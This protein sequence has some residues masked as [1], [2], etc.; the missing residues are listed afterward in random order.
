MPV[1]LWNPISI[2]LLSQL[3][4]ASVITSYFA[5][6]AVRNR[7]EQTIR[8]PSLWLFI[9][10]LSFNLYLF[11]NFLKSV[12]H[13]D[14]Q[15]FVLPWPSI[16][17]AVAVISVCILAYLFPGRLQ[18][19][20][21]ERWGFRLA[22]ATMLALELYFL[23]N[24]LKW[25]AQGYI[26][27]RPG[28]MDHFMVAGLVW[29]MAL[30]ARQYL[31]AR[32]QKAITGSQ[33]VT[34]RGREAALALLFFCLAP[35][36]LNLL[37][38]LRSFGLVGPVTTEI[39]NVVIT[40]IL[41]TAFTLVYLNYV[42]ERTSFL[43]KLSG[44]TLATILVVL[45]SV[46]WLISPVYS[47]A[48][49]S[50]N[51]LQSET[52]LRFEPDGMGG[53]LLNRTGYNFETD[54]GERLTEFDQ[55]LDLPFTFPFY[56]VGHD[57]F[58]I[59]EDGFL[60][61]YDWI[62]WRDI[63]HRYGALPAIVPLALS[64]DGEERVPGSGVFLKAG[65]DRVVVTW[66]AN[67]DY[68]PRQSYSYQVV[69]YPKGVI[70]I[71]Y[72][73]IPKQPSFSPLVLHAT[74]WFRGI[75]PGH[76]NGPIDRYAFS[77]QMPVSSP[78]MHAVIEDYRL[79]FLLYLNRVYRPLAWFVF[80]TS[81]ITLI[82]FPLFFVH[83][84][85]T[86]LNSLLR[87]VRQF[88][89]GAPADDL[90]VKFRDEIGYLT[91]SF[92]EMARDQRDLI[93]SLEDRVADRSREVSRI[94]AENARLQERNRLSGDLHDAVSQSL[95]S[96]ALIAEAIES[97]WKEDPQKGLQKLALLRDLNVS[98]LTEMRQ[99]LIE[100]RPRALTE[101]PL[102]FLLKDL[103]EAFRSN[104]E[105]DVSLEVSGSFLLPGDVQVSFL[106]TAQEGLGNIAKHAKATTVSVQFDCTANS[107]LLIIDDNGL[108]FD[109]NAVGEGHFGLDIMQ[110]RADKI[111]ATLEIE[112]G[113]GRGTRITLVWLGNGNVEADRGA[114][115]G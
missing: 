66:N 70:E 106:R 79:D 78:S 24:R 15:A 51:F 41:L 91:Q 27:Y 43:I 23:A 12:L 103:V 52:A 32:S 100:L 87:G 47:D 37:L 85:V 107:A 46:A 114:I 49:R 76:L 19:T 68:L 29:A 63:A 58:F 112:S 2:S 60:S 99:L 96:S 98:A 1:F 38:L 39:A 54:T 10:F 18:V 5:Y 42:P 31:Q 4:L 93:E 84:L 81:I 59:K 104:H 82:A 35:L 45:G 83:S 71:A 53:Y 56:G 30:F 33:R 20:P 57:S 95:F 75:T 69:L 92:S 64:L 48:Y 8:A 3:I 44:L 65:D 6:N 25:F 16:P 13:P 77:D 34:R 89:A 36:S 113:V 17:G 21:F 26:E 115:D 11:C 109:A 102:A 72:R 74:P 80:I 40:I 7:N 86:P 55:P 73:Q 14:F 28:W 94:A 67:S 61:F 105:T 101:K 110:D 50:S 9:V 62:A 108:G 90:P 97:D 111:G 22:C 88:R